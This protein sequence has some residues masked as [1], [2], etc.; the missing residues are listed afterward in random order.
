MTDL[1]YVTPDG[2]PLFSGLDLVVGAERI[3]LVG[4]NGIGKSTLLKLM[5]GDLA[6]LVGHVRVTGT[7]SALAQAVRVDPRE[8]IA[9]LF[10]ITTALAA[11]RRAAAG[12]ATADELTDVDWSLDERLAATLARLGLHMDAATPLAQLS[13]GQRARASL[14]AAIFHQPDFLLLDEPSNDLDR[15]GRQAVIELLADWPSGAVLVS[16]DRD[17]LEHV[18]AIVELTSLGLT[19][20]GGNWSAY[21]TRKDIELAAAQHDLAHAERERADIGRKLQLAAERKDR[22]DAAGARK[23]ARGDL[24]RLLAGRR[25]DS[26]E[27]NRGSGARLADRQRTQA[28]E[29]VNAAQA[30]VEILQ[31]LSIALASTGLPPGRQVLRLENVTAGYPAAEPVIRDLSFAMSGPERVGVVGP[32]GAGKTTLLRLV[33]GQLKPLAGSVFVLPD[34]AMLDQ[35]VDLLDPTA[36]IL[37]NFRRLNPLAD[38]NAARAA[39]ANFQFR[40]QSALQLAGTLSGGQSLRAG[41]A[42]RLGGVKPPSLLILDEPT[43]HLDIDSIEAIESG[44]R[45]YDGALLVVSHDESFLRNIRIDRRLELAAPPHDVRGPTA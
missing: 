2:R 12:M 4:R 18:D 5:A 27:A 9:D 17:L 44:L 38:D 42:C 8:T 20:Y 31:R 21:R 36:T 35:R 19:R 13:G 25:K 32:N 10:G 28:R 22:R 11:L 26:A 16:H 40:A 1:S 29:A 23:A 3:G 6:P 7:V 33:S 39:L 24:P 45:A 34:R 30:R 37:D 15:A 41:L 14:A 43:N